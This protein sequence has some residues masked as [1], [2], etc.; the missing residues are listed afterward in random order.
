MFEENTA[1]AGT[2]SLIDAEAIELSSIQDVED[3]SGA[4][5]G[6]HVT[7]TNGRSFG[8]VYTLRGIGN[9]PLFGTSGVVFY[10]DDVPQGDPSSLN[11]VLSN[12]QSIRV[13]RGPQG[14]LFGRNSSAG[15][16]SLQSKQPGNIR[17]SEISLTII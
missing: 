7:D 9:T 13:Y 16:V 12:L 5:P 17:E 4:V 2:Y 6:L 1:Y 14:H 10:L 8:N 3:L 15:V 11:P